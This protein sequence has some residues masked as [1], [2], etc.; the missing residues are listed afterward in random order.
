MN[1]T[2]I[3]MGIATI[4]VLIT[5]FILKNGERNDK[6]DYKTLEE[7]ESLKDKEET[8]IE[9]MNTET[10]FPE[11]E[12]NV[13][14]K[15]LLAIGIIQIVAGFICG[16]VFSQGEAEGAFDHETQFNFTIFFTWFLS[17]LVSG[18]LIIGFSEVVRLLHDINK[19]TGSYTKLE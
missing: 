18:V 12:E 14:A 1:S 10:N 2:L 5:I 15:L 17:T 4:V 8:K 7:N 6:K 9:V 13:I 3:F 16:I 11:S 19:K